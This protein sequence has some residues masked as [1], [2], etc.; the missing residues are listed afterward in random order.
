MSS[1]VRC[2]D[3][4]SGQ[5]GQGR[6]VMAQNPLRLV[7]GCPEVWRVEVH[8][9]QSEGRGLRMQACFGVWHSCQAG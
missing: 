2:S 5:A 4:P 1:G 8:A 7:P 9:M 6:A 3:Q